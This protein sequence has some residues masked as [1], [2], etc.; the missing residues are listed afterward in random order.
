VNFT[1][2]LKV[3]EGIAVGLP[4]LY[5]GE[6]IKVYVVLKEGET[7]TPEKFIAYFREN[8]TPYKV[9]SEV[10]FRTELPKSAIGKILRRALR[11]EEIRDNG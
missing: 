11:E 6:R 3:Q 5:K 10:E 4:D 2:P 1:Q 9:P 7:V 8:L